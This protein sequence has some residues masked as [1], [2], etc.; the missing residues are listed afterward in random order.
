MPRARSY[1]DIH[2]G[3][4]PA[5]SHRVLKDVS[6]ASGR[7][8]GIRA[9]MFYSWSSCFYIIP[10]GNLYKKSVLG[11]LC[12][13]KESK[14]KTK[15]SSKWETSLQLQAAQSGD[16]ES[17]PSVTREPPRTWDLTGYWGIR[18]ELIKN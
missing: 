16:Q 2:S 7:G 3:C 10:Q 4:H 1:R 14:S 9:L 15:P 8:V 17:T 5:M 18:T 11:L 6:M 12:G 13:G